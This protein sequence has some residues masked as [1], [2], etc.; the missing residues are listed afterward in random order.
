M[1]SAEQLSPQG[2][3]RT[4]LIEA[5]FAGAAGAKALLRRPFII[6]CLNFGTVLRG[7]VKLN[8]SFAPL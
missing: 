3:I 8:P 7:L 6:P 1:P 2:A 4:A 5:I